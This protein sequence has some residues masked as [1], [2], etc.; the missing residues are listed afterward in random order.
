MWKKKYGRAGQLQMIIWRMRMVCWIPKATNTTL[1]ICNTHC[2]PTKT[3][4]VSKRLNVTSYVHWLSVMAGV[5]G[6]RRVEGEW[7]RGKNF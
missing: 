4:V 5:C 3:V 2:F 6:A 1:R 7:R